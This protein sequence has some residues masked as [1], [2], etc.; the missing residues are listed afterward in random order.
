[1][2]FVPP[3]MQH[4]VFGLLAFVKLMIWSKP[5]TKELPRRTKQKHTPKI[6]AISYLNIIILMKQPHKAT[7][8]PKLSVIRVIMLNSR[9]PDPLGPGR[10]LAHEP[11]VR[12]S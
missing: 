4:I 2:V 1:M 9:T 6:N 7:T 11:H 3:L 12:E 5:K 8:L 10:D